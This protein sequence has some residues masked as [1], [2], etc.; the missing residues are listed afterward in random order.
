MKKVLLIVESQPEHRKLVTMALDFGDYDLHVAEDG[1]RGLYLAR[2]LAPDLVLLG[3]MKEDDLDAGQLCARIRED[4]S[5][6]HTRVVLL[7]PHGN[8][9]SGADA[10]LILPINPL[11]LIETVGR[12]LPE[13]R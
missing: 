2:G 6:A 8:Q 3:G 4:P 5:L 13:G 9:D 7:A 11:E 12:L 1:M 10:C